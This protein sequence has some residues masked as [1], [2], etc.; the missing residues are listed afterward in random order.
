MNFYHKIFAYYNKIFPYIK[1]IC[2]W[3]FLGYNLYSYF[4]LQLKINSAFEGINKHRIAHKKIQELIKFIPNIN[5]IS[6]SYW[7]FI[8]NFCILI[9]IL[10]TYKIIIDCKHKYYS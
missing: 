9:I 7:Y 2:F 5:E 4:L 8:I 6:D 3:G 10:L 1:K